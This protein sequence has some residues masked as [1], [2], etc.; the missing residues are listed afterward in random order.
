MP[1]SGPVGYGVLLSIALVAGGCKDGRP[2]TQS[3]DSTRPRSESTFLIQRD[4][5]TRVVV[6]IHGVFGDLR[7]TWRSPATKRLFP[8]MLAED[9][10]LGGLDVY[11]TSFA[12]PYLAH[13]MTLEEVTSNLY[14]RLWDDG[15]FTNYTE[16]YFV[17]HSMGGLIAEGILQNLNTP[18]NAPILRRVH[19]VI[20]LST[21]GNGASTAE[22]GD[23]IS[24]N[25]QLEDMQPSTLNSWIQQLQNDLQD[26][27]TER[28]S[29]DVWF[30]RFFAAYETRPTKGVSIVPRVYAV[31]LPLD[32]RL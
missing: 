21:P 4:G 24:A 19:A 27:R 8:E 1:F 14:Q 25:P 32:S 6:F 28:D 30:P 17:A 5:N 12:S 16:I 10:D 26:L 15:V 22:L 29:M 9:A 13:A 7:D 11:L 2:R 18:G 31:G 23:F 3:A 20:T